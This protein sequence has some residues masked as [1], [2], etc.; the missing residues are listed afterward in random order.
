[1]L[2]SRIDSLEQ[3]IQLLTD[4]QHPTTSRKKAL[5]KNKKNPTPVS[6]VSTEQKAEPI[7]EN[8]TLSSN[9]Q[10]STYRERTSNSGSSHQCMGTTKK[11]ARCKRMVSNGNYCW[12]HGG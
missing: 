4:K 1:V 11:G 8:P 2:E 7:I 6:L 5:T 9:Q 3:K 10:K 12:Q